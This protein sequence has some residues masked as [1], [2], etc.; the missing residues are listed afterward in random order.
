MLEV[1]T[2]LP[3]DSLRRMTMHSFGR[4]L[5]Y[6]L[7]VIININIINFPW[8][9]LYVW[10]KNIYRYY[11][12][13]TVS[14]PREVEDIWGC[15]GALNGACALQHY[16]AV[17]RVNPESYKNCLSSY[18]YALAAACS[19]PPRLYIALYILTILSCLIHSR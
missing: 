4:R 19:P 18:A 7:S 8:N 2:I 17:T 14:L 1:F 3:I 6:L 13:N 5:K 9:E 15:G 10:Y 16:C 11:A 12:A